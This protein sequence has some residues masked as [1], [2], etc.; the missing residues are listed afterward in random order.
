MHWMPAVESSERGKAMQE[1]DRRHDSCTD[2]RASR[3]EGQPKHMQVGRSAL[4]MCSANY[5]DVQVAYSNKDSSRNRLRRFRSARFSDSRRYCF[6]I[7]SCAHGNLLSAASTS[8]A[9]S[10]PCLQLKPQI[11]HQRHLKGKSR[12]QEVKKTRVEHGQ[13]VCAL[14]ARRAGAVQCD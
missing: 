8:S 14:G 1:Q 12:N 10:G 4:R 11:Y 6:D 9:R 13:R 2:R 5:Q 7:S 3:Q